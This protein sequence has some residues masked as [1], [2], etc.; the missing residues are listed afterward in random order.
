V[1]L[2]LVESPVPAILRTL[3][4]TIALLPDILAALWQAAVV[5]PGWWAAWG[6]PAFRWL[7]NNGH[8][9]RA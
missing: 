7:Q 1:L 4:R 5:L 8:L 9:W 2:S 3:T 6:Y